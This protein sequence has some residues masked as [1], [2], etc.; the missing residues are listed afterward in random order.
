MLAE[1]GLMAEKIVKEE[2]IYRQQDNVGEANRSRFKSVVV[3]CVFVILLALP[4]LDQWL[5]F[6][7]GFV[8]TEKRVLTPFPSF[9]YPHIQ[10]FVKKFGQY[11]KENFGWRNALF[12]QYSR[13]KY[14]ILHTSPLPEK[15]IVGKNGWF[16]PGNSMNQILDRHR[17]MPIQPDTLAAVARRLSTYQQ[18]LAAQGSKLYVLIAPDSYTIYPENLPD[19]LQIRGKSPNFDRIKAYVLQHTTIPVIDVREDLLSA[20]AKRT[21]Y[22]QTDTHWNFYGSLIASL[23]VVNRV[24]Q[25][26]PKIP[27]PRLADYQVEPLKGHGGDL[28]MMLAMNHELVDSIQYNVKLPNHLLL[29]QTEAT[30]N[31]TG[32]PSER[33]VSLST[34]LP[35]LLLIGD[36]YSYWMNQFLPGYFRESYLVRT[37]ELNTKLAQA[38]HPDVVIVEVAERNFDLVGRVE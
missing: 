35:K 14:H 5:G 31:P 15:V 12:Y 8:S 30:K 1:D 19:Y 9:Q 2:R 6:S 10:T 18:Q 4:T 24:R 22:F 21:V 36:S 38:E 37:H 17:G 25:D 29:R 11:Y 33:F 28:V 27:A 23:A 7:S 26:F 3:S 32:L 16:Y 34:D 20:K 13:W